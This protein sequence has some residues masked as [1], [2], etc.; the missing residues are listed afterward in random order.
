MRQVFH[1][2]ILYDTTLLLR[3]TNN[4]TVAHLLEYIGFLHE[5]PKFHWNNPRRR[6]ARCGEAL[7]RLYVTE[8][9]T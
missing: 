5:I 8:D 3:L 1:G 2:P 4:T 9:P 7:E 6:G